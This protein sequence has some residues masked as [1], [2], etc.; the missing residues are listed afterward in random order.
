MLLTENGELKQLPSETTVTAKY[1][2]RQVA[3]HSSIGGINDSPVSCDT[4]D[5]TEDYSTEYGTITDK[6][7]THGTSFVTPSPSADINKAPSQNHKLERRDL[8]FFRDRCRKVMLLY[9]VLSSRYPSHNSFQLLNSAEQLLDGRPVR[10][11]V[12]TFKL[13]ESV[14]KYI[15]PEINK[16]IIDPSIETEITGRKALK[17]DRSFCSASVSD[18]CRLIGPLMKCKHVTSCFHKTKNEDRSDTDIANF[19]KLI[20]PFA[21]NLP[22]VQR[23]EEIQGSIELNTA[24][25]VNYS[26]VYDF[27]CSKRLTICY[28]V[29]SSIKHSVYG[30]NGLN[31]LTE[32]DDNKARNKVKKGLFMGTVIRNTSRQISEYFILST[33]QSGRELEIM[34]R[35]NIS[36]EEAQE[37]CAVLTQKTDEI[38]V[39][40]KKLCVDKISDFI[41][42]PRDLEV[43]EQNDI[44]KQVSERNCFMGNE[45]I[46]NETDEWYD[47]V[48]LKERA[49]S[50]ASGKASKSMKICSRNDR[51]LQCANRPMQGISICEHCEL[52]L[53]DEANCKKGFQVDRNI[54]GTTIISTSYLIKVMK[55]FVNIGTETRAE[56]NYMNIQSKQQTGAVLVDFNRNDDI[57]IIET[58][59]EDTVF[60]EDHTWQKIAE[61]ME[62]DAPVNITCNNNTSTYTLSPQM[63]REPHGNDPLQLHI[64]CGQREATY[65][66][67]LAGV[68]FDLKNRVGLAATS[69]P[70]NNDLSVKSTIFTDLEDILSRDFTAFMTSSSD[71]HQGHEFHLRSSD[72]AFES[73]PGDI[74]DYYDAI[75]FGPVLAAPNLE[76]AL[77]K[78]DQVLQVTK[79]KRACK[80]SDSYVRV[81]E[82]TAS[83]SPESKGTNDSTGAKDDV[84]H[85]DIQGYGEKAHGPPVGGNR[86][87]DTGDSDYISLVDLQNHVKQIPYNGERDETRND[88]NKRRKNNESGDINKSVSSK[89][90]RKQNTFQY[91]INERGNQQLS[92]KSNTA[93]LAEEE[94][95]G[96]IDD[97][98][99][100]NIENEHS[101]SPLSA[102][103]ASKRAHMQHCLRILSAGASI[104]TSTDGKNEGNDLPHRHMEMDVLPQEIYQSIGNFTSTSVASEEEMQQQQQDGD[105]SI[106]NVTMVCSSPNIV[107]FE[108]NFT[109]TNTLENIPVINDII[110]P[111]ELNSSECDEMEGSRNITCEVPKYVSVKTDGTA[112]PAAATIC[113]INGHLD[114]RGSSATCE[115]LY[116]TVKRQACERDH[117]LDEVNYKNNEIKTRRESPTQN[118]KYLSNYVRNE[119]SNMIMQTVSNPNVNR[120]QGTK[121]TDAR[122]SFTSVENFPEKVKSTLESHNAEV[123]YSIG[124]KTE[125]SESHRETE[126]SPLKILINTV[127]V[128]TASDRNTQ[129]QTMVGNELRDKSS[130]VLSYDSTLVHENIPISKQAS[131]KMAGNDDE[132]TAGSV[133]NILPKTENSD[134]K[135][136]FHEESEHAD[137]ERTIFDLKITDGTRDSITATR[138]LNRF[139]EVDNSFLSLTSSN[140]NHATTESEYLEENE[141]SPNTVR[142]LKRPKL[143]C[144]VLPFE[145]I[146]DV[147]RDISPSALSNMNT[148]FKDIPSV[149]K[150]NRTENIDKK[151]LTYQRQKVKSA[152]IPNTTLTLTT[153]SIPQCEQFMSPCIS[154]EDDIASFEEWTIAEGH[155]VTHSSH[156]DGVTNSVPQVTRDTPTSRVIS[157]PQPDVITTD[158]DILRPLEAQE[159]DP[160]ARLAE[161]GPDNELSNKAGM[162]FDNIARNVSE[163]MFRVESDTHYSK[164][165]VV[166]RNNIRTS[167]ENL[168]K[169][170]VTSYFKDDAYKIKDNYLSTRETEAEIPEISNAN[171]TNLVTAE[172]FM[173][174]MYASD[175][176][177]VAHPTDYSVKNVI[178]FKLS[179]TMQ[180][181]ATVKESSAPKGY[182]RVDLMKHRPNVQNLLTFDYIDG[183]PASMRLTQKKEF[184]ERKLIKQ[185]DVTVQRDGQDADTVKRSVAYDSK[186]YPTFYKS[187]ISHSST[188][189]RQTSV[190][191][192]G[193]VKWKK[194]SDKTVSMNE[195]CSE[196]VPDR[197][198]RELPSHDTCNKNVVVQWRIY[199]NGLVGTQSINECL[200]YEN[201]NIT[202]QKLTKVSG[203][204][205]TGIVKFEGKCNICGNQIDTDLYV[206]CDEVTSVSEFHN[207]QITGHDIKSSAATTAH[208][209]HRT[210]CISLSNITLHKLSHVIFNHKVHSHYK[211]VNMSFETGQQKEHLTNDTINKQLQALCK[212]GTNTVPIE[213]DNCDLNKTGTVERQGS[214]NKTYRAVLVYTTDDGYII[215]ELQT[216]L[217][218]TSQSTPIS[219]R[220]YQGESQNRPEFYIE[221][222]TVIHYT[223]EESI[224]NHHDNNPTLQQLICN[225]ETEKCARPRISNE[226]T[227][228]C[229]RPQISKE[230]A[231]TERKLR[232][233]RAKLFFQKYEQNELGKPQI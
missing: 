120:L 11:T 197:N 193:I 166:V 85:F 210:S 6:G 186:K 225:E 62:T 92:G 173:R 132:I 151:M 94:I 79:E 113:E 204:L 101:G 111:G 168:H 163:S 198:Q 3:V 146:S 143:S 90:F 161:T 160:E 105:T 154:N 139:S 219:N 169:V 216:M 144:S 106:E 122:D 60:R 125:I 217:L 109:H 137:K 53:E 12:K 171:S 156:V 49:V 39:T 26:S 32:F 97:K 91:R 52:Q 220:N 211:T 8:D 30:E 170:A 45:N 174:S 37:D 29:E 187:Y 149:F 138:R 58:E 214:E 73:H 95:W 27:N 84:V 102:N 201:I 80:M 153:F 83:P 65:I 218:L 167:F 199:G 207:V 103:W 155:P 116:S 87:Y 172:S 63:L 5:S 194:A 178:N 89:K 35:V 71:D 77:S 127:G 14:L 9:S 36:E 130:L 123:N 76:E 20:T 131:E 112:T 233:Q 192:T 7:E 140:E 22:A 152:R 202:R 69:A 184:W 31:K 190:C 72:T 19:S 21:T 159:I 206:D 55:I 221:Q 99:S 64:K 224:P 107:I 54:S 226:E 222:N 25:T 165:P 175:D 179:D 157:F 158:T 18:D 38:K 115:D 59:D 44:M 203:S 51:Y 42:I 133:G 98:S 93:D 68:T 164:R 185:R 110:L 200:T 124:N 205:P 1:I 129:S 82:T 81:R 47:L 145:D 15:K 43:T 104:M 13:I 142:G 34:S 183:F 23:K 231:R 162:Y 195:T 148:D 4:D 135:F 46:K 40:N 114:N 232:F 88:S 150:G 189:R 118:K 24:I 128:T 74:L 134:N 136:Q 181:G 141:N 66:S 215:P 229:A 50:P 182:I 212:N 75:D 78:L 108:N 119:S 61:T 100:N 208:F 70:P 188:S 67:L 17:I 191:K 33:M 56:S 57:S 96:I 86:S 147:N 223:T 16:Y 2:P 213:I 48:K 28:D 228:K 126:D 176:Y 230:N 180:N 227:E 10:L 41:L 121:K 209:I 177:E 117:K 196:A